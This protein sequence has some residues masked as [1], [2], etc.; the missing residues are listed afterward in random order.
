MGRNGLKV[1]SRHFPLQG[2]LPATVPGTVLTTLINNSIYPDPFFGTNLTQIPDIYTAGCDFYTYVFVNDFHAG[3]ASDRHLRLHFR[4]VNYRFQVFINGQALACA[5]G[6]CRGMFLQHTADITPYLSQDGDN[7]LAV[8]VYPPNPVGNPNG[9]QGGDGTIARNVS[10]QFTAG[11]DWIRPIPDRNTGIWDKVTLEETGDLVIH[12]PHIVTHVPGKREPAAQIQQP[13]TIEVS[14]DVENLGDHPADA[15][16]SYMLNDLRITKMATIPAHTLAHVELPNLLLKNPK[17]WW[18]NNM[19]GQPLY[20]LHMNVAPV[21]KPF[22]DAVVVAFGVREIGGIWNTHTQSREM[23]VNGQRVF[24]KGGNWIATDALY[25]LSTQKYDA[26]VRM[27][28]N[29]NLNLIRVWGGGLTERPEFYDACDKYGILVMQDFWVSG[30]CNGRWQD[31]FKKDDTLTR[32]NYPDDHRLFVASLRDQIELL[33]NHPSLAIWCGGNEIRPPA[34]ILKALTD[35]LLP[36]LDNTR[37]FF[38]YS[39]DD[40][41]SLH[42]HDGPYS[43]QVPDSFFSTRSFAFNSEVGSI[44]LGD[45][46]SLQRFLPANHLASLPHYDEHKHE[47]V[48]DSMWAYHMYKSYDSTILAFGPVKDVHDFCRKAQ[49]VN[50]NQYRALMEGF[51]SHRWDWYTGVIIWKT[52]NPWSAMLGQMYDPWLDPNACLYGTME[53][54]KPVHIFWNP[55]TKQVTAWNELPQPGKLLHWKVKLTDF[56]GRVLCSKSGTVAPTDTG[57]LISL[58][59]A[60]VMPHFIPKGGGLLC[61]TLQLPGSDSVIDDNRYLVADAEDQLT[62]LPK[63]NQAPLVAAAHKESST[64]A[65]VQLTNPKGNLVAVFVRVAATDGATGQRVLPTFYSDNYLTLLPGES[66]K[67]TVEFGTIIPKGTQFTV[68]GV[69]E[70]SVSVELH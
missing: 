49:I 18:P 16:L 64:T 28:R 10:T 55:A 68:E 36:R 42:A 47:W 50:Y 5:E 34:D 32:R 37:A 57:T 22:S 27:H 39:N 63:G 59:M 70:D 30:D 6:D 58:G 29:M 8:A 1:S 69:N 46:E 23:Q 21:G 61:L 19:G 9:G 67:I 25:R 48:A 24:I 53:G 43:I 7:R 13:A 62:G 31:D 3:I 20:T 33:R 66:R 17:L 35:T 14:V 2:F 51:G 44:G 45:Y 54:A 15:V 38:A 11:W 4:G 12:A 26:A 41:M 60:E 52:E 56:K 65:T 40:S